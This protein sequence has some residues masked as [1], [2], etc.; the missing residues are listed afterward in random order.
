VAHWNVQVDDS[1]TAHARTV[2]DYMAALSPQPQVLVLV[3]AHGSMMDTYLD[4]LRNRT[5]YTW[6][7]VFQSHC[8]PGALSGGSCSRY[9]D[10]GVAVLTAL[11]VVSSSATL[12]PYADSWHSARAAVRLGVTLNGRTVQVFGMHLQPG[13]AG[14]RY[15]S[16]AFFKNWAGGF[17]APQIV[18]GDFNADPDQIDT[19][20]GMLPRFI[21]SWSLVGSGRGLTASAPN[22]TMKLDYWF[23][24]ASAKATPNWSSVVLGTGTISDHYPVHTSFTIRP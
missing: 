5:P 8:P 10:E 11:P 20:S 22:P 23:A 17:S 2:I 6:N 13:N 12:L 14:A 4:E 18:G 3:E 21:D 1:S 9:E 16:M 7:G 15:G 24:D 19:T